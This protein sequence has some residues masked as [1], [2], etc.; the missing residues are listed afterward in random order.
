[1]TL[2]FILHIYKHKLGLPE[3]FQYDQ[4]FVY[5]CVRE[6]F[7]SKKQQNLGISPK[8]F[9]RVFLKRALKSLRISDNKSVIFKAGYKN[10]PN[11]CS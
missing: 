7:Q 10:V 11:N 8:W 5:K 3:S 6:A 1:M 2:Y 9:S 4:V